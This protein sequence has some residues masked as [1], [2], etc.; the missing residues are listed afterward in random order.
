MYGTRL[1]RG[2]TNQS[3]DAQDRGGCWHGGYD[4]LH[5]AVSYPYTR[6]ESAGLNPKT[7]ED[8]DAIPFNDIDAARKRLKTKEYACII[9]EPVMGAAGF[10][11]PEPGYLQ[12]LRE[13]CDA[14]STL[15]IFDEVV[16]GFRLAPGGAQELYGVKPDSPS[17]QDHRRLQ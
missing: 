13:A 5:K 7:T 4:S 11:T 8:T 1:A 12:G 3:E 17:W 9:L 15:L 6:S 14:T 16:T 10:L 2:Y